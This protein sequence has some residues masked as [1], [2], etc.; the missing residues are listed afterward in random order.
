[1][2]CTFKPKF[3]HTVCTF[4]AYLIKNYQMMQVNDTEAVWIGANDRAQEGNWQWTDSSQWAFTKWE[5]GGFPN[6]SRMIDGEG[7]NCA[8]LFKTDGS[9]EWKA[10]PCHSQEMQ[11]VCGRPLCSSGE[12]NCQ[13]QLRH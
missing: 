3:V 8:V 7:E 11:F 4:K 10:V 2:V 12:K 13:N 6:N 5:N 9:S 1:M